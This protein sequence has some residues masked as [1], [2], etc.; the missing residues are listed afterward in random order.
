MHLDAV[1]FNHLA[2]LEDPLQ[3]SGALILLDDLKGR[4][5]AHRIVDEHERLAFLNCAVRL[6]KAICATSA[7]MLG[8][9][10]LGEAQ[11]AWL[12]FAQEVP[13]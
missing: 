10:W 3:L 9:D 12:T 7:S 8:V 13:L 1:P 11:V 5:T 2:V 6:S 4:T